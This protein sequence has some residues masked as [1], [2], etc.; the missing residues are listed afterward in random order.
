MSS[1]WKM[2]LETIKSFN[3]REG[4]KVLFSGMGFIDKTVLLV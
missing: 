2:F 1:G 3:R 4:S